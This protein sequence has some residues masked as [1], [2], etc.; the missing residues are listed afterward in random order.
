MWGENGIVWRDIR[1]VGKHLI[2]SDN[3]GRQRDSAAGTSEI[4]EALGAF[5]DADS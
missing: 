4:R 1:N 3:V 2:V 5:D